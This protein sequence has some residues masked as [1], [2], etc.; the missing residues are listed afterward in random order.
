MPPE[1][2][3]ANSRPVCSTPVHDLTQR[4]VPSHSVPYAAPIRARL[5]VSCSFTRRSFQNT[6]ALQLLRFVT[7]TRIDFLVQVYPCSP[8]IR[9][10]SIRLLSVSFPRCSADIYPTCPHTFPQA[11]RYVA[12]TLFKRERVLNI[13]HC[14]IIRQ[15]RVICQC[16]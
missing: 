14:I 12:H 10:A 13:L 9:T 7:P 11:K 2:D 5:P 1:T 4:Y 3:A 16:S 6:H 15:C 8:S